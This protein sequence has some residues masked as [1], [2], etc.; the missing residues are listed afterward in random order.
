MKLKI[1][2]IDIVSAVL[3]PHLLNPLIWIYWIVLTLYVIFLSWWKTKREGKHLI[4]FLEN[5]RRNQQDVL[6]CFIYMVTNTLWLWEKR[7]QAYMEYLRAKW[8]PYHKDKDK[9]SLWLNKKEIEY[10]YRYYLNVKNRYWDK[11]K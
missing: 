8:F 10:R 2:K 11:K 5:D 3:Y 9:E 7:S 6:L 1:P 4:F